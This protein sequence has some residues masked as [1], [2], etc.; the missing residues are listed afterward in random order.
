MLIAISQSVSFA[1]VRN[2]VG[3]QIWLER[4]LLPVHLAGEQDKMST[5]A[6]FLWL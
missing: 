3:V 1:C 4:Q 5:G 2:I 6:S